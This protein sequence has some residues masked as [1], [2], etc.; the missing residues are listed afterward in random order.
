MLLTLLDRLGSFAKLQKAQ[1]EQLIPIF[2]P[3]TLLRWHRELGHQKWTFSNTPKTR[4]RP[5]IEPEVVQLILRMARENLWGD[6][7]IEGELKKLG[8]L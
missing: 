1:L 2:K 8:Y 4:G 6:D 3:E 7:R 5:S